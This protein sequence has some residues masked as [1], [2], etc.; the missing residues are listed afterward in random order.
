M[1]ALA[2]HFLAP[3]AIDFVKNFTARKTQR[4]QSEQE[5]MMNLILFW[6]LDK[7]ESG[8]SAFDY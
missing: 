7:M 1:G 8:D 2:A 3:K 6:E 4:G 5:R